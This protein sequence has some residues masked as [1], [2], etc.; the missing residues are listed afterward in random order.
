[1]GWLPQR[2][3][4]SA[5]LSVRRNLELVFFAAGLLVCQGYGLTET[6]PMLTCNR[7]GEF[8]FGSV[9]KPIPGCEVRIAADGE[10]QARGSNVMQGYFGRPRDT[11]AAF[12]SP[13]APCGG[14]P[15]GSSCT[16]R[17]P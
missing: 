2:L 4:L 10:I 11:A 5:P 1:M 6:S 17:W 7:P 15:N 16:S 14:V 8:R 3:A 9:G 13:G 12:V